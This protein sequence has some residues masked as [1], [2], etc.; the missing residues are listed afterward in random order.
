MKKIT[1]P[2]NLLPESSCRDIKKFYVEQLK[3]EL[4]T[5]KTL[6]IKLRKAR[7]LERLEEIIPESESITPYISGLDDTNFKNYKTLQV[8]KTE[9]RTHT[10]AAVLSLL[11]KANTPN[12][13]LKAIRI[14]HTSGTHG[15]VEKTRIMIERWVIKT[16]SSWSDLIP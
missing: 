12:R 8:K 15:D 10:A 5:A 9:R 6:L 16:G 4:E 1:P 11:E 3:D 7:T 14:A 13:L 2:N